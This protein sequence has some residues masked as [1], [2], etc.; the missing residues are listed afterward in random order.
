MDR[1]VEQEFLAKRQFGMSDFSIKRKSI[2]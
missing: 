2:N 1:A